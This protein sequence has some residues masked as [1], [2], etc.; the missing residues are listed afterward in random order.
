[1]KRLYLLMF[2]FLTFSQILYSAVYKIPFR[3]EQNYI[4]IP[5]NLN[6]NTKINLIF[7]TGA[8][9]HIFFEPLLFAVYKSPFAKEISVFGSDLS[10]EIPA[11]LTRPFDIQINGYKTSSQQ[12]IVLKDH[13]ERMSSM[14][15]LQIHGILSAQIFQDYLVEIDY[16]K[17]VINLYDH[18][19]NKISWKHFQSQNIEI[20]KS[21]PYLHQTIITQDGENHHLNLLMDTGAGIGLILFAD[22]IKNVRIPAQV[23]PS[24]FGFGLGGILRGVLGKIQSY[25]LDSNIQFNNVLT[26]FQESVAINQHQNRDGIVGNPILEQFKWIL[27]Y[28]NNKLY[29]QKYKS[30]STPLQVDRSGMLLICSGQDFKKVFVNLVL[31]SSPAMEADIRPNDELLAING[32]DLSWFN[33][34]SS[35][36]SK[37]AQEEGT[38]MKLKLRRDKKIIRKKIRLKNLI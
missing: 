2:L 32:W 28:K 29:Y 25:Y 1:M 21:K 6:G 7:D 3:Y 26:H 14:I 18:S 20:Y 33:S 34:F 35:I 27:D 15:G 11:Y 16:K 17:R 31:N 38:E 37:F 30:N 9:H 8:D 23:I 22:S 12:L 10:V 36:V 24:S 4:I 5:C 13:E 19:K